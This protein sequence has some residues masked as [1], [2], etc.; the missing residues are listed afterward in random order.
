MR[1]TIVLFLVVVGCS[2]IAFAAP[3]LPAFEHYVCDGGH[4]RALVPA[5][6]ERSARTAPYADMT[7]V[8]GARFGGPPN[9]KGV[10]AS[11]ALY[12]YSGEKSFTT[13]DRY[14]NAQLGSMVRQDVDRGA[15]TDAL[16][17]AGRKATAFHITTFEPLMEPPPLNGEPQ[18]EKSYIHERRAPSITVY[19]EEQ[20]IVLSAAKG[21]YVLHYR[22]PVGIVEQY[23]AVFDTVTA[24]FEPLDKR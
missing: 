9:G 24:S 18:E 6:W 4:F 19:L 20:Y 11:I 1:R 16:M 7:P 15:T 17:L 5:G 22:A 21:Y 23:Q 8:A 13:P 10:P 12:W 14:I 2:S 3:P